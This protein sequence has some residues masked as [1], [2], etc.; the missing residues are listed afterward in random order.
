MTAAH[1]SDPQDPHTRLPGGQSI[2]AH[3]RSENEALSPLTAQAR[4]AICL[5]TTNGAFRDPR[6]GRHSCGCSPPS[7][8]PAG[9]LPQ[10][11]TPCQDGEVPLGHLVSPTGPGLMS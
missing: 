6:P 10:H 3:Y 2:S 1:D 4:L 7:G 11:L 8:W 5:K 9:S